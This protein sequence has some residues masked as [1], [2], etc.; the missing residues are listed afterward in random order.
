EPSGLVHEHVAPDGSLADGFNGR[1]ILP[2]HAIEAMWFLMDLAGR[3]GAARP[4]LIDRAVDI[5]LGTLEFGWDHEYGGLYYF[6]DAEGHPPDKLEWDRKLWW[7]HLEALVA[8]LKALRLTGRAE[9]RECFERVH[10]YTW[11][12]FP[13]PEFGEWFG[14]LTREGDVFLPLKGGKWKGCFH[15]P[16]GLWLCW[17]ELQQIEKSAKKSAPWPDET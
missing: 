12:R 3:P 4:G 6:L 17:R 9:C 11:E 1:L 16:R 13:D 15:V 8:L 2:G 7:A 14:Y 10:D 5:V